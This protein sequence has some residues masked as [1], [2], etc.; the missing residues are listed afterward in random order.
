MSSLSLPGPAGA[1]CLNTAFRDPWR[2]ATVVLGFIAWWPLGLA[3]LFL[4]KGATLMGCMSRWMNRDAV[5]LPAMMRGGTGNAAF[6]EY[7]DNVLRRLE[8]ERRKLEEDR[9]AF[10][11]FLDQ[12]KRAK[13]R[14]EFDRFMAGRGAPSA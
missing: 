6:D 11:G 5:T 12:L 4:L 10:A 2:I 1:A 9:Q 14:E 7:R 3:L 13:D 8:E